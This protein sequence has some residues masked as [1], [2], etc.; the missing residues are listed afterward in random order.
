MAAYAILALFLLVVKES[1]FLILEFLNLYNL[2]T[3]V[4]V[5]VFTSFL[6]SVA[7]VMVTPFRWFQLEPLGHCS[8][9]GQLFRKR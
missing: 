7:V 8:V 4:F 5:S 6:V 3:S 1:A 9:L 2:A